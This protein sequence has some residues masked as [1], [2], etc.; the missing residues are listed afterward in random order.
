MKAELCCHQHGEGQLP[1]QGGQE[2]AQVQVSKASE[3]S[4]VTAIVSKS[5]AFY[6]LP[7]HCSQS[8]IQGGGK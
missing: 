8:N 5:T 1:L 7:Y 2:L 6:Y 4:E 3:M